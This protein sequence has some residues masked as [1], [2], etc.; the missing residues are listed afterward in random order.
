MTSNNH[1]IDH[2]FDVAILGTGIGG[3]ILGTILARQGIK[4]LLL[5][6]GCHPRFTIGESTIPETTILLRLMA[7]R[8]SVPEVASLSNFQRVRANISSSC[9]VKRNFSFAYHRYGEPHAAHETT[10]FPTWAPPYGPDVHYF[11]QDVDA[12]MLA[13]AISYGA[14]ARQQTK[15]QEVSIDSTGVRLCTD[16]G[17]ESKAQFVVDAGGIQ[18]PIA[19][20][21]NLRESPCPL[22]TRS[23]SIFTHMINVLP[24]DHCGP[25]PKEHRMPSP[26]SQGTLHHLFKGGWMWVIPFDNHPTSTNALCSVG[27]NLD[28]NEYPRTDITPEQEF[29]EIVGRFP[30]IAKQFEKARPARNWI[31][32]DR[33]QFSSKQ[34][35]G[36]RFCLLPHAASFVDPLF[37]SGL[38]ITMST[39]N[40]LANRLIRATR[41]ND[42]SVER[43]Q[44]IDT[45]VKKS[46]EYYDQLVSCSYIAFSDFELWNAWHRV[47]M[48]GGLYGVSALFE[49]L[50]RFESIGDPS[51]FDR[52]EQ[53]P[54][55]GV[56]ALDLEEYAQLLSA[57]AQEVE[58]VRDQK[59]SASEAA[60]RIYSLLGSSG[61]CPTP[62]GLSSSEKRCPGTFTLVP[63]L[64]LIAWGRYRS[65][66]IIRKHYFLTG[67]ASGLVSDIQ[68]NIL[69]EFG[70]LS[71]TSFG[72]LRDSLF[73]WNRDWTRNHING[74]H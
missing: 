7:K 16:K 22:K 12:Y 6:Q 1:Q 5:E 30:S 8:Y 44:Y 4:V 39:I 59:Q 73:S 3:T 68:K 63:M 20:M 36:E 10:Q 27:V 26:F 9:G 69:D 35:V 46:F 32:T 2:K 37:S 64:R 24:Y 14:T 55:R 43:F 41:E 42:F 62:W 45:W 18:A 13:T 54:Y 19:Q 33:L 66:D 61:L 50:S 49:V 72:L 67:R 48:L 52:S 47:W 28:L 56:Q 58:A 71:Q 38:A 34:V 21:L 57:T 29:W 23:R 40:V 25:N 31:G 60:L 17:E 51:A 15:V 11:R 53:Y 70:R 74:Q 65:P